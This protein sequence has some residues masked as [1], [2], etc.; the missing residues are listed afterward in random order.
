MHRPDIVADLIHLFEPDYLTLLSFVHSIF[1]FLTP[2]PCGR[3]RPPIP[4]EFQ[5]VVANID[6]E[7]PAAGRLSRTDFFREMLGRQ[8][9]V[10]AETCNRVLRTLTEQ[11]NTVVVLKSGLNQ[12]IKKYRPGPFIQA[13]LRFIL[14]TESVAAECP[15]IPELRQE[16]QTADGI[17]MSQIV[18]YRLR[19]C[20]LFQQRNREDAEEVAYWQC[21]TE[22]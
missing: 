8:R 2:P 19:E 13:V 4:G 22:G 18:C 16:A 20:G 14:D 9:R 12:W 17:P 5:D 21:R 7:F 3:R 1:S 10:S 15:K 6:I 11:N